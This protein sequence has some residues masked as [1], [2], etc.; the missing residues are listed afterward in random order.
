MRNLF[1]PDG[2]NSL[3]MINSDMIKS[4]GLAAIIAGVIRILIPMESSPF[5]IICWLSHH[6]LLGFLAVYFFKK[7]KGQ[8]T[9]TNCVIITILATIFYVALLSIVS[10]ITTSIVMQI[11]PFFTIVLAL[12]GTIIGFIILASEDEKRLWESN[13]GIPVS[14]IAFIYFVFLIVFIIFWQCTI[15]G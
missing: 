14:L 15:L 13:A 11:F 10:A 1:I 8:L 7:Q 2:C 9:P 3:S 4:A 5:V 6:I 12:F